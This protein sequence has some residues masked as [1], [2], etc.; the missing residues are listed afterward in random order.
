MYGWM[1]G[2]QTHKGQT[3][4]GRIIHVTVE[5]EKQSPRIACM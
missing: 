5:T 4:K 1:D 3:A 2:K